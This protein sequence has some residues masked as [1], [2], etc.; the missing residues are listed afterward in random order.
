MSNIYSAPKSYDFSNFDAQPQN[1]NWFIFGLALL[2][3]YLGVTY[4]SPLVNELVIRQ[5]VAETSENYWPLRLA[6]DLLQS[7]FY[8]AVA[9]YLMGKALT[10]FRYP[11]CA[12]VS[13]FFVAN[14]FRIIGVEHIFFESCDQHWYDI[15]VLLKTPFAIFLGCHLAV[16]NVVKNIAQ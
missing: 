7:F 11:A 8:M 16:Q 13:L 9:G 10:N 14:T 12:L 2:I 3:A 15:L 1:N 5:F 6:S 4:A